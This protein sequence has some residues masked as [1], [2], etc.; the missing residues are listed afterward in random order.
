MLFGSLRS[1][2]LRCNLLFGRGHDFFGVMR[3]GFR[4]I[5]F[6][7]RRCNF[8]VLLFDVG[9]LLVEI[10]LHR[11]VARLHCLGA[12]QG[13][14]L[15]RCGGLLL[16]HPARQFR[17]ALGHSLQRLPLA[18][19]LG[20]N[21][22]RCAVLLLQLGFQL[23]NFGV[24]LRKLFRQIAPFQQR[25]VARQLPFVVSG[26][27]LTVYFFKRVGGLVGIGVRFFQL[28][29]SLLSL[30][31]C[32]AKAFRQLPAGV[33]G[34]NDGFLQCLD[35]R[36]SVSRLRHDFG[37]FLGQRLQSIAQT[38]GFSAVKGLFD[39]SPQLV[40]CLLQV[41]AAFYDLHRVQAGVYGHFR[42]KRLLFVSC[43]A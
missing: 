20:S 24:S 8:G 10:L 23:R 13:F 34:G 36:G 38:A 5:G 29:G 16:L 42:H 30:G 32:L 7:L 15:V 22:G 27:D 25:G 1:G 2:F 17:M 33:L 11:V 21:F 12:L 37:Q 14:S 3:G 26:V 9:S 31:F 40:H 19:K 28:G 6:F 35:L 18:F 39:G 43:F 4:A 41:V